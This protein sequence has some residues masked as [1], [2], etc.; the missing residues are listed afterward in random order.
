[1]NRLLILCTLASLS[2]VGAAQDTLTAPAAPPIPPAPP[3]EVIEEEG[4]TIIRMG[5]KEFLR[6]E[7]AGGNVHIAVDGNNVLRVEESGSGVTLMVNDSIVL[8]TDDDRSVIDGQ[9]VDVDELLEDVFE[10]IER[11]MDDLED[12]LEDVEVTLREMEKE[13]EISS[14][15]PDRRQVLVQEKPD[16]TNISIGTREWLA[17]EE[18]TD[19]T[20]IRVGDKELTIAEDEEGRSSLHLGKSEK[21]REKSQRFNGHW[22]GVELGINNY[23][24]K[25]FSF[26]SPAGSDFDLNTNRSMNFN[27]N[28][29]EFNFGIAS[30]KFGVVTG[31]GLEW[32]N[33][34]FDNNNTVF[35]DS[36]G[37]VTGLPAPDGINYSKSKLATTYLTVPLLLEVQFPGHTERNDRVHLAAGII[38]GLKLDAH[39][40]M[41]YKED[42]E[43]QKS[44]N[45]DDFN[46]ATLRYALTARAGYKALNIWANV[47]PTPLF[48]T[49]GGPEL[50]PYAVGLGLYF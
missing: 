32:C 21:R 30:D 39:T 20:R 19:T 13:I 4:L 34:F 45:R 11:A 24:D 15:K 3:I 26:G 37:V 48:E 22:A 10:S 5:D 18:S 49:D 29:A 14:S 8:R 6:V 7:E 38:G 2:L 27:L 16:G 12:S 50:Y 31:A 40:K 9:E 1:M 43:K 25:D 35:K 41:V 33:Y 36:L 47:Y 17:V 46:L 44:K 23:L 42:G 28:F